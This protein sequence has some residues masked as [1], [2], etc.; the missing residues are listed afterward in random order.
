LQN[1]L[2]PEPTRG[3]QWEAGIKLVSFDNRLE[4]SLAAFDLTKTKAIVGDPEDFNHV[5]QVGELDS[6]GIEAEIS[7]KLLPAW[8]LVTSYSYADTEIA[9]DTNAFIVGHRMAG[10]PRHRASL[11]TSWAVDDGV[12]RGLTLGGGVFY[13]SKQAATTA[14]NFFLPSYVR[15]DFNAVYQ[16]GDGYELRLNVDN[17]TDEKIY[18][19]GGFSQIY[20]QAP[21]SARVTF[22]KRW[23]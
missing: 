12:L 1:D 9:R 22:T 19:T 7:A 4:T 17:V 21:V 15:I 16:Y 14:N 6:R 10:V 3:E 2:L 8:T 23:R 11:W 20:P 18:I 5:I 13:A